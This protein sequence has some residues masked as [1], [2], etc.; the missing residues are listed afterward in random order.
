MGML[1]KKMSV[2]VA[3]LVFLL[4]GSEQSRADTMVSGV[5]CVPRSGSQVDYDQWGIHNISSSATATVDCALPTGQVSNNSIMDEVRVTVF[6]RGATSRVSCTVYQLGQD[7]SISYQQ[8]HSTSSSSASSQEL[9]FVIPIVPS[10]KPLLFPWKIKCT[11][12][13]VTAS[14]PSHVVSAYLIVTL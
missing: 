13:P 12:P 8:T 10:G 3:A 9:D 5:I 4:V 7:G 14:G 6:D 2:C 1:L 11:L